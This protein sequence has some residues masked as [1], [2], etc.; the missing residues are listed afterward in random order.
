MQRGSSCQHLM[1]PLTN[2]MGKLAELPICPC[3]RAGPRGQGSSG[4]AGRGQHWGL[5]THRTGLCPPL[6][7]RFRWPWRGGGAGGGE[8][9]GGGPLPASQGDAELSAACADRPA[10]RPLRAL[11]TITNP[12]G[13]RR[14]ETSICCWKVVTAAASPP[15]CSLHQAPLHLPGLPCPAQH[16]TCRLGSLGHAPRR[17]QGWR[18]R[19]GVEDASRRRTEPG[20]RHREEEGGWRLHQ[21]IRDLVFKG[22]EPGSGEARRSWSWKVAKAAQHVNAPKATDLSAGRWR[23]AGFNAK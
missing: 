14:L 1:G 18:T 2:R 11:G 17:G 9:C 20:P 21:G 22:A 16:S 8:G 10:D 7:G 13:R 15:P 6:L 12:L 19:H 4:L 3:P 23:R 5:K